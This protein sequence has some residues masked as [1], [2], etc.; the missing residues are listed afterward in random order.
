MSLKND[1]LL[2]LFNLVAE[3]DS[4]YALPWADPGPLRYHLGWIRLTHVCRLWRTLLIDDM[5]S[6]WARVICHLPPHTHDTVLA[7]AQ[8]QPLS[9]T[10][11]LD[12]TFGD[13]SFYSPL[14]QRPP[15]KHPLRDCLRDFCL[16]NITRARS[17][18]ARSC[19]W[20][21]IPD[22]RDL[23]LPHLTH[24]ELYQAQP[25]G[26]ATPVAYLLPLD[27]PKL[28]SVK[29]QHIAAT[30][31]S[32]SIR[33][34][35][36]HG[37]AIFCAREWS[38]LHVLESLKQLSF[39]E[40]EMRPPQ[41]VDW[42]TRVTSL[43]ELACLKHVHL[44]GSA[45]ANIAVLFE[46]LEMPSLLEEH[47]YCVHFEPEGWEHFVG[48]LGPV[49]HPPA[50]NALYIV[51][52]KTEI[53]AST[54]V[55]VE[56]PELYPDNGAIQEVTLEVEHGEATEVAEAITAAMLA[57]VH[58]Q[59]I[60]QI[61]FGPVISDEK[62]DDARKALRGFHAVTSFAALSFDTL[63]VLRASED[64][65]I[66][67]RLSLLTVSDGRRWDVESLGAWWN[68]LCAV[69]ED[70]IHAGVPISR[71]RLA[72]YASPIPPTDALRE[73][74]DEGLARVKQ[75]VNEVEDTRTV[76]ESTY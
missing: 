73:I 13:Q 17:I 59:R 51:D 53:V 69:L 9:L 35:T 62:V 7:R 34:L 33:S 31:T 36:L 26:D 24:I 56:K 8:N 15:P 42:R 74:E 18:D 39:L 67:P 55:A 5:P 49:L 48:A 16:T 66:F 30:F 43:I 60:E 10:V 46:L 38:L 14:N 19:R 54:F 50:F 40:L 23:Q 58:R 3:T 2:E 21:W 37:N 64:G 1:I 25:I 63:K 41:A 47:L 75:L 12:A 29:L 32:T 61:V 65:P 11:S 4:P 52:N 68:L 22:F 44:Y 27:A 70:R 76:F 20:N 57:H 28:V 71:I 72:S 6:L 45:N